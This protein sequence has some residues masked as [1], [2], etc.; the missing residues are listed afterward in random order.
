MLIRLTN[1]TAMGRKEYLNQSEASRTD[2]HV[3]N[4]GITNRL[5]FKKV[6]YIFTSEVAK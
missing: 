3:K 1:L 2:K 4:K 6:V 5:P